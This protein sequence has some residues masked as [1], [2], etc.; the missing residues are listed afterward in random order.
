MVLNRFQG[1][2]P[3]FSSRCVMTSVSSPAVFVKD[4]STDKNIEM[5]T[6]TR[7]VP[8]PC[9]SGEQKRVDVVKREPPP[10]NRTYGFFI[11]AIFNT[12]VTKRMSVVEDTIK[13][14]IEAHCA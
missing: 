4:L 3:Q 8:K 10:V 6:S 7:I 13:L 1:R 12:V 14:L 5:L 2:T 9:R 11:N